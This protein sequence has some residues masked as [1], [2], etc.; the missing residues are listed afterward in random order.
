MHDPLD[1]ITPNRHRASELAGAA[2]AILDGDRRGPLVV[3]DVRGRRTA[4]PPEVQRLL[5]DAVEHLSIGNAV[6]VVPV[7]QHPRSAARHHAGSA[8]AL[9]ARPL[10]RPD[11]DVHAPPTSPHRVDIDLTAAPTPRRMVDGDVVSA[12][13]DAPRVAQAPSGDPRATPVPEARLRL[14]DRDDRPAVLTA[15]S[16][17]ASLSEDG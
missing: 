15:L 12:P 2:R 5:V 7:S 1:A 17:L 9:T 8:A 11:L 4:L 16:E 3:T 14:R 10:P 6:V 13:S